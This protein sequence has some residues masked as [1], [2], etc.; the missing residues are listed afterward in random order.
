MIVGSI[1]LN[2]R[3]RNL[4]IRSKLKSWIHFK[5]IDLLLVQEPWK[6]NMSEQFDL[7]TLRPIGGNEKVFCWLKT[8]YSEKPPNQI[9]D[10][11]QT[12]DVGYVKLI[13]VYLNA[14]EQRIRANQLNQIN[15]HLLNNGNTPVLIVG[16]FNLAPNPEDGFYDGRKSE[17]NSST[18]RVP[19][20][21]LLRRHSLVDKMT[22]FPNEFTVE[23]IKNNKLIQF[24]C[25]LCLVSEFFSHEISLNYDHTLR[26]GDNAITDHSGI[27]IELPVSLQEY[28]NNSRYKLHN[29]A[30]PRPKYPSTPAK[31]VAKAS[32]EF[33]KIQSVLDY[34]CGYGR[35]V[36]FYHD[37]C[38]LLAKGYDPGE[39]FEK[40]NDLPSS[41]EKFDLVTLIYVLNILP[42]VKERLDV[43]QKA[44]NYLNDNGA[45]LV[46]T[47]SPK[48][49]SKAISK[50]KKKGREWEAHNDGY[51]SSKNKG[52][53]QRG[54]SKDEIIKLGKYVGLRQHPYDGK[55]SLK[56]APCVLFQK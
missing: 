40:W 38:G 46:V 18:D 29:T 12:I 6:S 39:N 33:L 9:N 49:I 32:K 20:Q 8:K 2:K 24:R 22:N 54:I 31:K 25:D 55:I 1:N 7:G 15:L 47:R 36:L 35:D 14:Y 51:W 26:K 53:F 11:F 16:D 17:F 56:D 30:K 27:I 23:K 3:L 44:S 19:F 37:E 42:N 10:Y 34:G 50:A 5:E 45:M 13:N 21:K 4:E 41:G 43:L 52:T 28:T 48:D